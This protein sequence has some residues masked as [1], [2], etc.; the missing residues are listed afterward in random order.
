MILSVSRRTDIPAFYSEWFFKRIQAGYVMVRNP[1]NRNQV[2]KISLESDVVDCFVF[3]TKNPEEMLGKLYLLDQMSYNYY[4]QFTL[5]PYGKDIEKNVPQKNE[6]TDT[7]IRLSEKIGKN[8]VIW[9]YDPILLTEKITTDYHVRYFEYLAKKLKDYTEKCIISFVDLYKKCQRNLK[10]IKPLDFNDDIKRLLSEKILGIAKSYGL[11]LETCAED[12]ELSDIGIPHGKCID[13]NLISQICKG[14]IE[15]GKDKNQREACGCITSI[16]IGEYNTCRHN[17][18]YCYANYDYEVVNRNVLAHNPNSP[19]LIGE[20]RNTDKIYERK[21]KNCL[22]LQNEF[23]NM[24]KE[25]N[26]SLQWTGLT[27][28][29]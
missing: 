9:R 27:P 14:K 7:F 5:N 24:N 28:R 6:I 2:S 12:I 20:E 18:L 29:H 22:R 4:F 16:D 23:F 13:D 10:V 17:C 8:K 25:Y 3:W 15:L 26:P 1:M 21:M 11:K 19:F